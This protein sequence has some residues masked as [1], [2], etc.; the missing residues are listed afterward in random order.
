[1][2]VRN[3]SIYFKSVRNMIRTDDGTKSWHF[4]SPLNVSTGLGS[5][6]C[7]QVGSDAILFAGD[8]LYEMVQQFCTILRRIVGQ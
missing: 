4:M 8:L 7:A 3:G 5:T 6:A 1:M 2:A